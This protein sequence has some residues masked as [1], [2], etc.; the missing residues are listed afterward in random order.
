MSKGASSRRPS[1]DRAFLLLL[2][3]LGGSYVL[4][5]VA[6]LAADVSS[7][8]PGHMLAALANPET[9]FSIQLSLVSCTLTAILSLWVGVP[10]GYLMSRF[11]L[12][13]KRLIDALLD[14]PIV[15]PP[16]VIGLSLLI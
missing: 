16:L 2:G 9:R 12:P 14:V 3:V 5:I 13:G 8:T 4:L 6:L 11:E 10:L 15:L 7:T 1:G